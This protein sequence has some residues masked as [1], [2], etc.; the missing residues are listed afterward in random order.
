MVIRYTYLERNHPSSMS[1][2]AEDYR[3]AVGSAGL[4]S[5]TLP[6][7]GR[8]GARVGG[9]LQ[10]ALKFLVSSYDHE[11]LYHAVEP[12]VAFRNVSVVTYHI[13]FPFFDRSMSATDRRWGCWR[14]RKAAERARRIVAINP[15]IAEEVREILGEEAFE[16][17]RVVRFPLRI[18]PLAR[19]PLGTDVLWTGGNHPRKGPSQFLKALLQVP[20]RLRVCMVLHQQPEFVEE[21][22]RIAALL[23]KVRERHS[24][25]MPRFPLPFEELDRL[26]RS[27][28]VYVNSSFYEGFPAAVFEAYSRGT[29]IVV[30]RAMNYTTD[31]GTAAGVFYYDYDGRQ[32]TREGKEDPRMPERLAA[33]LVSALAAPATAPDARV[34]D[35]YRE[36]TVAAELAKVYREL[37]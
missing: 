29:R 28:Q 15:A 8:Y 24:L 37:S 17:T 7:K 33:S 22:A 1:R 36:G 25:S 9:R 27:S 3:R 5:E 16:K 30:P 13:L 10:P 20:E 31:Y 21:N 14:Y 19:L 18:P 34:L 35:L 2:V 12:E 4:T 11:H 6:V 32:V 26:Y 23:P